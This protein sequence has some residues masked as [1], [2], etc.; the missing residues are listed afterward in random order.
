[1]R[2]FV[3]ASGRREREIPGGQFATGSEFNDQRIGSTAA[4][5][6]S[7]SLQTPPESPALLVRGPT[8]KN[9]PPKSVRSAVT[10][11]GKHYLAEIVS[12]ATLILR[13]CPRSLLVES[14]F[15]R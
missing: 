8:E 7:R 15:P 6:I 5:Q 9:E 14:S 3:D 13:S 2:I 11:V 1:M 4:V 10:V 12:S